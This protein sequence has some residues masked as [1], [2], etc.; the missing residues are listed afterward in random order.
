MKIIE[1]L[2]DYTKAEAGHV[3]AFTANSVIYRGALIMGGGAAL[4]AREAF[5][6]VD[7]LLAKEIDKVIFD[8]TYGAVIVPYEDF[9]VMAFQTKTQPSL[10]SYLNVIEEACCVCCELLRK[11]FPDQPDI[12]VHLNYPGIGLGGLT[13]DDVGP[14]IEPLLPDNII[15]YK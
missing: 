3:Y 10:P 7:E 8:E 6:G 11:M 4:A 5:P 2:L 13:P 9:Y 1:G 15:V 14:I 12:P